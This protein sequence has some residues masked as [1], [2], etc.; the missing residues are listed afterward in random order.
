MYHMRGYTYRY[1]ATPDG[2]V[3]VEGGNLPLPIKVAFGDPSKH[4]GR[5]TITAVLVQA[6]PEHP[7]ITAQLLRAVRLADIIGDFHRYP[8]PGAPPPAR[9]RPGGTGRNTRRGPDE[10]ALRAFARTY[11]CELARRPWRAMSATAEAHGISRATAHRW[12][13]AC[14]EAGHLP[15]S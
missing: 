9:R 13:Q 10:K 15:A 5:S 2:W 4:G 14:R 1:D 12:A 11:T 6:D 8:D 3:S 7:E